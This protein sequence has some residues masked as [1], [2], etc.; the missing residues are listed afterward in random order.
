MLLFGYCLQNDM[1]DYINI[2]V[3]FIIYLNCFN[4][5]KITESSKWFEI[6]LFFSNGFSK[7]KQNFYIGTVR[8]FFVNF[9]LPLTPVLL[10]AIWSSLSVSFLL[11]YHLQYA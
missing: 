1:A 5:V 3:D 6:L 9:M 11:W 10:L 4:K 2:K 7:I 8:L